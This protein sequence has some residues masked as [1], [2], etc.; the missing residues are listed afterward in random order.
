MRAKL[1]VAVLAVAALGGC[2]GDKGEQE[3][4]DKVMSAQQPTS[5]PAPTTTFKTMPELTVDPLGAYLGGKRADKLQ[6]KEGQKKLDEIIE[7]LP[8]DDNPVTLIVEKKAKIPDV[9][10]VVEAFGR[11]GAPQVIVKTEGRADLP[12]ELTLTPLVHVSKPPECA[13]VGAI[14]EELIVA[15]WTLKGGGG[16]K[17]RKGWAGPDLTHAAEGMEKRLERC[18]S[19]VAFFSSAGSLDWQMAFNVGGTLLKADKETKIKQLVL[20]GE[21]PVGGRKVELEFKK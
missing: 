20:L 10:V 6:K 3:L 8:V 12:K 11:A 19:T 4:I 5:T 16:G 9:G 17:F 18:K 13:V 14:N 21:E 15:V 7:Q 2:E 1:C